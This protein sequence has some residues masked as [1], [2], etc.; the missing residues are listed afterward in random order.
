MSDSGS[1]GPKREQDIDWVRARA[2]IRERLQQRL[3]RDDPAL[4]DLTQQ[5][6]IELL[7]VVRRE[8]AL[9]LEGLIA[10]VTRSI[11]VGEIRRRQRERG[12]KSRWEAENASPGGNPGPGSEHDGREPELLWFLLVQYLRAHDPR[13][14]DLAVAYAEMG[15]WRQV[16]EAMGQGYDATRQ[17]WSRATRR[18]METLRRDPGP[19]KDWLDDV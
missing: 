3:G 9:T 5:A 19:F 14:H 6:S 11:A 8:G 2:R 10:V 16:A 1:P 12:G 4:D 7:R 15:D 18:F 13:G 17:Q